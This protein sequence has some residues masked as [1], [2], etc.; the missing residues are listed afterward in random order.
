MKIK[1]VLQ[2]TYSV[3]IFFKEWTTGHMWGKILC[4]IGDPRLEHWRDRSPLDFS[5]CGC[6]LLDK[7]VLSLTFTEGRFYA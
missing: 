4:L 6:E 3:R 7:C 1:T 5:L 2:K